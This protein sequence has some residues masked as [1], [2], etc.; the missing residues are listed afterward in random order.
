MLQWCQ[1]HPNNQSKTRAGGGASSV[2]IPRNQITFSFQ[3]P[4]PAR[5]IKELVYKDDL[6]Y[7]TDPGS[8]LQAGTPYTYNLGSLFQ[9]R[10]GGHQPFGF[11]QM[12][13]LYARY[14]VHKVHIR[15]ETTA[16]VSTMAR[17]AA[18]VIGIFPPGS[19]QTTLNVLS[20]YSMGENFNVSTKLV[21]SAA[22]TPTIFQTTLDVATIAGLTKKEFEANIEDYSALVTASPTRFP[23]M[24][25]N[26]AP[27]VAA[28]GS[29]YMSGVTLTF[30]AEFWQRISLAAS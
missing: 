21:P 14:K 27:T 2:S 25:V 15:V 26:L 23:F 20:A 18:Q 17:A 13:S 16:D 8:N 9:P 4:F 11:D 6:L 28:I 12:A 10:S 1:Y 5:T 19:T 7:H 29:D 30:V 24:E 3:D 22:V